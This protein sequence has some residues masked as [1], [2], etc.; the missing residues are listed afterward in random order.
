MF[1]HF[2][3]CAPG[4]SSQWSRRRHRVKLDVFRRMRRQYETGCLQDLRFTRLRPLPR[5]RLSL[6]KPRRSE[7]VW[8]AMTKNQPWR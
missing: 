6:P 3:K 1:P 5:L 8:Y 2:L 7:S 4:N